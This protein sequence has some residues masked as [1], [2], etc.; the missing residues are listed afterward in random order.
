M[1]PGLS[2]TP[3]LP[4]EY[5]DYFQSFTTQQ[6]V[7]FGLNQ[8]Y[9]YVESNPLRFI[10]PLG[11][12]P[13]MGGGTTSCAHYDMRCEQSGGNSTYY[14]SIAPL[15]CNYT[16]PSD[17]TRC[18]R[19]CLQDFDKACGRECDGSPNTQCTVNAHA[20]CWVECVRQ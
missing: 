13:G 17:W 20:H 7:G 11:L 6:I 12:N 16:P 1:L 19:K 3:S 15:A 10:D 18:V 2:P 9:A 14:C 8:T 5:S 4:K